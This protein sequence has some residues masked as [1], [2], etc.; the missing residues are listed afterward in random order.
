[1]RNKVTDVGGVPEFAVDGQKWVSEQRPVGTWRL[2]TPVD[3]NGD[4]LPDSSERRYTGC[5]TED[6]DETVNAGLC[7][8]PVPNKSGGINTT[9]SIGSGLTISALADWAGGHEVFD[10]G[11]VWAT[12]NGIYRRERVRCGMEEAD[13][14]GCEYAFPVQYNLDGTP[15][16]KYS[17]NTARSA[18]LYDGDY[19][20]L[21]E[22][23]VRY[24]LPENIASTVRAG[25]ATVYAT[26]QNLWIWSRNLMIDG[27]LNGLS[28]GGLQ[29][30]GESSV[31]LS[32]NRTYRFGVEVVF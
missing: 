9:V 19:F 30:G 25:R 21:R 18:F 31:T 8:T 6:E 22:I 23:S 4:G 3:T 24:V 5:H 7:A 20:K 29:L 1:V 27:E 13:V 2:W 11:S 15:R 12:F 10:F 14:E 28:G 16:G 32:P 17:Q 26:G